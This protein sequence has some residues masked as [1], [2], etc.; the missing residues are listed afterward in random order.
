[1]STIK[2]IL[3]GS[4][5]SQRS[6]H[7][8]IHNFWL[9]EQIENDKFDVVWTD[10]L[11]MVSDILTKPLQGEQFLQLRSLLLNWPRDSVDSESHIQQ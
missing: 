2:L 5:S 10:T 9:K 6:R 7:I 1:M 11:S 8:E 3:K 4:A